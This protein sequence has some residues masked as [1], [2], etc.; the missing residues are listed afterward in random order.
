MVPHRLCA[1]I[2]DL[3]WAV[4]TSTGG[5]GHTDVRNCRLCHLILR[6][7]CVLHK[8]DKLGI[9][10][11]F[12]SLLW[13]LTSCG[14][15]KSNLYPC[16]QVLVVLVSR[17]PEGKVVRAISFGVFFIVVRLLLIGVSIRKLHM[18][19]LL[20]CRQGR[21]GVRILAASTESITLF[22]NVIPDTYLCICMFAIL[23]F[24]L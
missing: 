15:C 1:V 5:V 21:Y 22:G 9:C 4:R 2:T 17:F 23:Q 3:I 12:F 7:S 16:A 18:Q 14:L 19:E 13:K 11:L 8:H 24:C 10:R 20:Y 6:S